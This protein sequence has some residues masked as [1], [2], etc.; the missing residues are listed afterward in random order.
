ML[1]RP[2]PGGQTHIARNVALRMMI[3]AMY[4]ITSSQIAGGP[5]WID[6]EHYD[7]DAKA[8]RPPTLE[9]LHEM[10]RTL[11]AD[12]FQLRYHH[13]TRE[14]PAYVLTVANFGNQAQAQRE[15]GDIR[16]SDQARRARTSR[17][18]EGSNVVPLLVF[19][20]PGR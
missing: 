5:D 15:P 6:T 1:I 9:E 2:M 4:R 7:I 17:G 11:L 14:I 18:Y 10:F 3:K 8:E 16:C 13:K 12:R 20:V 19:I